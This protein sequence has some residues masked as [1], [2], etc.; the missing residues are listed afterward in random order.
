MIQ[1]DIIRLIVIEESANEAEVVFRNLRKARY[2]IRP[3]H[4][5]DNEDLQEALS[6]NKQEWDLIISVP[7]V[8]DFTVAQI[9]ETVSKSKRDI[10]VIVLADENKNMFELLN[11][12]ATQVVP[13]DNEACLAFVVG[14]ELRN[15]A[16]RRQHQQLEQ[17]C[18]NT[19]K[20]NQ[21]LLDSSRDAIAYI[22]E[23]VLIYANAS[24]LKMFGY[25]SMD[26]LDGFPIMDL[27]TP[28]NQDKFKDFLREFMTTEMLEERRIELYGVKASEQ[29]F[30]LK[31]AVSK[32][33]Y[34]SEPRIQLVIHDESWKNR[35]P[36]TELFNSQHFLELLEEALVNARERQTRSVLFY[37]GLDKFDQIKEQVG[38]GGTEPMIKNIAKILKPISEDGVLARFGEG[39]FTLLMTDEDGQKYAGAGDIAEKIRKAVEDSVIELDKQSLVITCSIGITR[40]L[41][42]AESPQDVLG[43][44]RV[45]C[46]NAQEK[47]GNGFKVYEVTMQQNQSGGSQLGKLIETA[48]EENRLSL[49]YQPIVSLQG[50]TQ[51]IF[52]VLLRMVDSEGQ[53]V[54]NHELFQVA[55]KA[56]LSLS[57]DKWIVQEAV[58]IL[59][60]HEKNG[61]KTYFFIKLTAQSIRGTETIE[62][63]GSQLNSTQ[64]SGENLVF[65]ISESAAQEQVKLTSA[66]ISQLNQF[67]C[68]SAL[69]HFGKDL[70]FDT[71][72]KHLPVD[73]VKIDA[74]YSKGGLL[75]NPESQQALEELVKKARE[76]D[77]QVIAVAVENADS[78]A[79]LWSSQVN[80]AQ[81]NYIQEP[82]LVPDFDFEAE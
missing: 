33:I 7:Q 5:G 55:E 68:K 2:P 73:Y 17:T 34:D 16:E 28:N 53:T 65:E 82:L 27:I 43:E 59:A 21:V 9:C 77:K 10:P 79:V 70:N 32:A 74:S 49:V 36:S 54:A 19:Q 1:S 63:I 31:M 14:R 38:V 4:I 62:Y 30:K 23:G 24:Y 18:Q 48:I 51:A 50:E 75:G 58:K 25:T 37:I 56:N 45:A 6:D 44:A 15:L 69:E 60:E 42:A 57:L 78:L 80:F 46:K 20:Q 61:R 35:D 67:K 52:E 8:G 11:A 64:L 40:V 26:D 66:F 81:G 76:L 22:H 71:I 29:R 41:A 13:S 72:L 3:R 39:V 12:G 47:G